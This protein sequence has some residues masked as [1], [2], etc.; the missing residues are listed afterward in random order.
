MTFV[1]RTASRAANGREIVR[2]LRIDA[3][4]LTIGRAPTCDIHLP[5]LQLAL[6]HAAIE[7]KGDDRVEVT[8]LAEMP[9]EVDGRSTQQATISL[10][11]GGEVLLGAHRLAI[12][13]D[14]AG[15][16]L[17]RIE[18]IG[19]VSGAAIADDEKTLFSL[20]KIAPP[21]RA[22][23]WVLAIL[24]LAAFLVWPIRSFY[25]PPSA[26]GAA[27]ADAAW[28]PGKLSQ[29]HAG[30]EKNCKACHQAAFVAVQDSGCRSCHTDTHDHAA[31]ARLAKASPI[32]GLEGRLQRSISA[33]FNRPPGRCVDCHTEH[34]GATAMAPT[35]QRF[36]ADCHGGLKERLPDTPFG[37]AHDFAAAH[38]QFRPTI[39]DAGT[40]ATLR[41]VSL[42]R[43]PKQDNGLTFPHALHL[44]TTNA[45]ARMAQRQGK[46]GELG[47]TDCHSRD[48]EGGFRPVSME[49]NCQSCHSLAFARSDGTVRTL[50]HGDPR[51]VVAELRDFFALHGPSRPG[52]IDSGR[53]RPGDFVAASLSATY[54]RAMAN[55]GNAAERSIRAV[56]SP[57]GACYDCHKVVPPAAGGSLNFR[58]APVVQQK[59]YM[60]HALFD[61]RPHASATCATCHAAPTSNSASDLLMPKIAECRTCHAGA[62]PARGQIKSIC[63]TCHV[64]HQETGTIAAVSPPN[65][66]PGP[67]H[68]FAALRLSK[69]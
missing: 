43:R 21:R 39:A 2:S 46:T 26:A 65:Q 31:P 68:D 19:D 51:Q 63:A 67:R 53:R 30:L 35:P 23:A 66:S 20:R 34:Q 60:P 54:G 56:F 42:D 1:I 4:R 17:I 7:R 9:F 11:A 38:P 57:G 52:A 13:R 69:R 22:T 28:S 18:R 33:A 14:D 24:I 58:I 10:T 44:S 61:H 12:G 36:C 59:N 50:R 45:V 27:Q 5:D 64:Y 32:P 29:A 25:A 37:D 49:A 8:A 6:L 40:P 47:C 3:D 41:R 62:D 15:D 55:R 48:A 16:T